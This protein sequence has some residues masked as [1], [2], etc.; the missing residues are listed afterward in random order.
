MTLTRTVS[1]LIFHDDFNRA[2]GPVGANYSIISGPWV[3]LNGKLHIVTTSVNDRIEVTAAGNLQNVHVQFRAVRQDVRS[4][5][6]SQIRT[7]GS[8]WFQ[9]DSGASTD[10]DANRPRYYSQLTGSYFRF[11]VG[12]IGQAGPVGSSMLMQ[13]GAFGNPTAT[14]GGVN[15][16][17]DTNVDGNSATQVAGKVWLYAQ[18]GGATGL[19]ADFD[20]LYIAGSRIV[21]VTGLPAGAT[22]RVGGPR[23]QTSGVAVGGT[24]S[25][26]MLDVEMPAVLEVLDSGGA[27]IDVTAGIIGGD[28][29]NH[30]L[31]VIPTTGI[32]RTTAGLL[33]A[34]DFNRAN[35]APGAN[36]TVESGAW[37]I[38]GN[39]LRAQPGSGVGIDIRLAA[40]AARLDW[41]V[42][43]TLS[44]SVVSNYLTLMARYVVATGNLYLGDIGGTGD[45]IDPGSSRLYR[46]TASAG[47]YQRIG[48]GVPMN[49][50][51]NVARR[52]TL[53]VI[54][55][56]QRHWVDGVAGSSAA[57][58][59]ADN[60]VA[61]LLRIDAFGFGGAGT[62]LIDD[63][64]AC[65]SRTLV[66]SG[67]LA[68]YMIVC[69]ALTAA[70][71]AG[72]AT[73]DLL[74]TDLPATLYVLNAAG[75]PVSKFV[76][77]YGGDVDVYAPP[78]VGPDAP[79][80]DGS[81]WD[82]QA[83]VTTSAYVG[84][85][86]TDAHSSTHW[87]V[88]RASDP[89]FAAPVY[90]SL[91]NI[92]TLNSPGLLAFIANVGAIGYP[93][94][95]SALLIRARHQATSGP[96]SPWSGAVALAAIKPAKPTIDSSRWFDPLAAPGVD[97]NLF[98]GHPATDALSAVQ[99]QVTHASDL[100]WGAP[101]YDFANSGFFI[102]SWFA[103]LTTL[104]HNTVLR[105]RVRY[106]GDSGVASDWSN[107]AVLS[108]IA[109]AQPVI[110][111]HAV[112]VL[113]ANA[114][115]PSP[116][117]D[118]HAASQ[119]QVT[120]VSDPTFATPVIDSGTDAVN[121]TS[122]ALT[123][124]PF[125]ISLLARVR[126]RG[127]SGAWSAWSAAGAI[128]PISP[129]TQ[130]DLGPEQVVPAG[131]AIFTYGMRGPEAGKAF[132]TLYHN[133]TMT[134]T[135]NL[136]DPI[137]PDSL[138]VTWPNY[139]LPPL[140][141]YG[142]PT[143]NSDGWE[144]VIGTGA[145][146]ADPTWLYFDKEV[147]KVSVLM[148]ERT[149]YDQEM[150]MYDKYGALLH[151]FV[152]TN[153]QSAITGDYLVYDMGFNCVAAVEFRPYPDWITYRDLTIGMDVTLKHSEWSPDVAAPNTAWSP[154][155][156][157]PPATVWSS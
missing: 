111:V 78:P 112:P 103:D 124:L 28:T 62:M 10:G 13:H 138:T 155:T 82:A 101:D 94:A 108:T 81:L 152:S 9:C 37:D 56:T 95:G 19:T 125:H 97:G 38:F 83:K 25:V 79:T 55:A 72:T 61:G 46:Y 11:A 107:D 157:A 14:R 48:G 74:A 86:S 88:T 148:R 47:G 153:V 36:W 143:S 104:P 145:D 85:P 18:S 41:H 142:G 68:G 132:D 119:W 33:F 130:T 34:D 136:G 123:S 134:A 45:G 73:L 116:P 51:A 24:A 90:D 31:A 117:Q 52:E 29:W 105:A 151:T 120:L 50:V 129:W 26:D 17:F 144:S 71:V 22:I 128:P 75:V 154:D 6:G 91:V 1:G 27:T 89:T 147:R 32:T 93:A 8:F 4:Y 135:A 2:D 141:Y 149:Y 139:V 115:V 87:Q 44:R 16:N 102:Y 43:A 150:R 20:E 39:K 70:E 65:A 84:H 53:S 15:G 21:T 64:V 54:G 137:R 156:D 58:A 69:G 77:T 126:Y 100:V 60:Q 98:V 23:G 66:V 99:Y 35:G 109:P 59:T 76:G 146:S 63:L 114:F 67:L 140:P 106:I 121:L 57:D 49:L 127:A 113:S 42:Q 5:L 96:Y 40:V 131:M 92:P 122:I 7:T 30:V 80:L 110:D 3:I 133:V 118:T 12:Y